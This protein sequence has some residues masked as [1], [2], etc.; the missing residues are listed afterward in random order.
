MFDRKGLLVI[1]ADQTN[2]ES[3]MDLALEAGADDVQHVGETFEIT[4]SPDVYSGVCDA[5]EK[6]GLKPELSEIARIP[7]DTVELDADTGRS[8][9]K[10]MELLD[11]HD[12]VQKVA[13]NFNIPDEAMA[14]IEA[15]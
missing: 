13:S 6:A 12:D 7:K 5:I 9:L 2:E 4:C 3:L 11:D 15:S 10:L 1:P 14:E 8:V